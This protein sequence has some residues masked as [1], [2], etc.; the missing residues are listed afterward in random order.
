MGLRSPLKTQLRPF[1]TGAG[2][3]PEQSSF[4]GMSAWLARWRSSFLT[5]LAVVLPAVVSI[6]LIYL[7]F[8]TVAN[9]TDTLLLPLPRHWR[10]PSSWCAMFR[11]GRH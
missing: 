4:F 11:A 8:G 6:A 3:L 5:G 10:Y 9:V 7:V 1:T 2:R